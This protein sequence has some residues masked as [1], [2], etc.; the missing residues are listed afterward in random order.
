[1]PYFAETTWT[2]LS[3][4]TTLKRQQTVTKFKKGIKNIKILSKKNRAEN[5]LGFRDSWTK[6]SSFC[7]YL[8][9]VRKGV[10]KIER[11]AL[12]AEEGEGTR[13]KPKGR[14]D[15]AVRRWEG[16]PTREKQKGRKSRGSN[17]GFLRVFSLEGLDLGFKL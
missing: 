12:E 15:S 7:Q 5:R 10:R 14:E 17:R 1:M 11:L 13:E 16:E 3:H 9:I 2:S 8:Y 6:A 4:I